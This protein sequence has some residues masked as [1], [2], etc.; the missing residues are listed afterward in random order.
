MAF[1]GTAATRRVAGSL[2]RITGLSLAAAASGVIG[3]DGSGAE[4]ELPAGLTWAPY[5]GP[6]GDDNL[7]DLEESVQVSIVAVDD[8]G[9][10][11]NDLR[12]VKA[13]GGDPAA[14]TVTITN[15]G[16]GVSDELEIYLRYGAG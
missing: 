1:T 6:D 11:A 7:V 2:V 5:A 3:L 14:F 15:D 4:V 13:N 8:A 9:S 10:A 16:G 12:V